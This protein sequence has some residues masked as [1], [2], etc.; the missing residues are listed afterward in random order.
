M[1]SN[2]IIQHSKS[3]VYHIHCTFYNFH[4][5]SV[6]FLLDESDDFEEQNNDFEMDEINQINIETQNNPHNISNIL[7]D[8]SAPTAENNDSRIQHE[9]NET[10]QIDIEIENNLHNISNA[11]ADIP[12]PI[13][14]NSDFA[15]QNEMNEINAGTQNY[16][17]NISDTLPDVP[18]F[19]QGVLIS[20]Q[21]ETS[22][23]K[24]TNELPT[25]TTIKLEVQHN[26]YRDNNDSDIIDI[27][28]PE[29]TVVVISDDED[30]YDGVQ[31][32]LF[33]NSETQSSAMDT[34]SNQV[35]LAN[36]R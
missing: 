9:M 5:N 21:T 7:A 19:E 12:V 8:M 23:P 27:N 11:I 25:T 29:P 1:N 22:T 31:R 16:S 4:T 28:I 33:G 17:N 13:V 26:S 35:L 14:E 18:A 2:I 34:S 32:Q 36:I 20:T 10:T 24:E 3:S 15:K 6:L 30:D